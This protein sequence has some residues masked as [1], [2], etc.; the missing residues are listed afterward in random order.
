[1]KDIVNKLK[2]SENQI[3][4]LRKLWQETTKP[5][6]VSELEKIKLELGIDLIVDI[7]DN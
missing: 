4:S 3:L 1:M 6:I 2:D 7:N 5:K